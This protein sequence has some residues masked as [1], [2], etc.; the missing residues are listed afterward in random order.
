MVSVSHI[1]CGS[2]NSSFPMRFSEPQRMFNLCL[3]WQKFRSKNLTAS[4]LSSTRNLFSDKALC[5]PIRAHVVW[6]LN[7]NSEYDDIINK[8]KKWFKQANYLL[9]LSNHLRVSTPFLIYFFIFFCFVGLFISALFWKKIYQGN[10]FSFHT[11]D[12][13]DSL[14]S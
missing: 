1:Y 12:I 4:L 10:N 6:K 2:W 8:L 5:Q 11:R 3:I 9:F 13:W 14:C 7:Y